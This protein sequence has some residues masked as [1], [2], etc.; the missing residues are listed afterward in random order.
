MILPIP[1][2]D[3]HLGATHM[4]TSSIRGVQISI[5]LVSSATDSL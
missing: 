4:T 1:L 3:T 2:N 5:Y